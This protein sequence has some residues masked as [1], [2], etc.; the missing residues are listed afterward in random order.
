M[1]TTIYWARPCAKHFVS[2]RLMLTSIVWDRVVMTPAPFQVRKLRHLEI[3]N[4]GHYISQLGLTNIT[5]QNTIWW[6]KQ[7][8]Y[9]SHG[10]GS[11]EVQNQGVGHFSF[12]WGLS[13]WLTDGHLLAVSSHGISS[14]PADEERHLSLFVFSWDLLSCDSSL[15]S[16]PNLTWITTQSLHLQVSSHWVL[17]LWHM[18]FGGDGGTQALCP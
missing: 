1:V 7:Q 15:I 13:S 3:S 9:T 8:K 2:F 18:N 10:S 16:W 4:E 5:W 14:V 11:W 12:S 6:L 17:G